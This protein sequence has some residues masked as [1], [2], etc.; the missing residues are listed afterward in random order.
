MVE[1]DVES[2]LK[3]GASH[4]KSVSLWP[5]EARAVDLPLQGVNEF[6]RALKLRVGFHPRLYSRF[7]SRRAAPRCGPSD[8]QAIQLPLENLRTIYAGR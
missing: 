8:L 7:K 5:I 2:V 4:R 6:I 1:Q 3:S